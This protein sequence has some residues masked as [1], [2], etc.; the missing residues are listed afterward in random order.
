MTPDVSILIVNYNVKDYLLQCLRSI[1]A[2]SPGVSYEVVVVDN[3]SVDQSISELKP[4]FPTVNWIQLEENVGF[5]RGNNRGLEE[6]RGRYV[7]FLN[8]DTIIA[9]DTLETMVRFMD[10]H[11]DVGMAGC[12]V[13]NPD[14]T[15]QLACRRG[16]PTPWASFCKLSG[17]QSLF[18]KSKLFARYN[19]TYLPIDA[20]YEVDVLIGAFM[21]APTSL[22]KE[23]G[24]FDPDFFMYGEDV[25]LCYRVKKAGKKVMYTHQ[26]S[27]IHFKGESTRRS[28]INEVKVFYDAMEIFARKH[29]SRS[30]L[31]L[32]MMKAG[33]VGRA[34]VERVL[35]HAGSI[36]MI[37]A[38]ILSILIALLCAT[39]VRF[40][41]P[42]GFPPYAYPLVLFVVP[43]VIVMSL[44]SVGEY[45]EYRPTIRRSIVG[46]LVGFFF[47]SALTYFFKDFAF[48]RGVVLMTIG[49]SAV[50]MSITRGLA[51]AYRGLR[52]R[53][54]SRNII[55]VGRTSQAESII[56]SLRQAE[57]RKAHVLGVVSVDPYSDSTFAQAPIL[58]TMAVL[59]R[60]VRDVHADEVILA[61][62]SVSRAEAMTVMQRCAGTVS[63][64]HIA[65]EYSDIVTARIIN[66]V[67]G[68]EPTVALAPL[69]TFRNR[70]I[71]RLFDIV[72]SLVVLPFSVLR[73]SLGST[74]ARQAFTRWLSVLRGDSSVVGLYPDNKQRPWNK[75]GILSLVQLS[76]LAQ[77]DTHAI[78]Q[79]NDYY[80]DYFTIA[81]DVDILFKHLIGQQRGKYGS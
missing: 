76:D 9:Q 20:T 77:L 68:V 30:R 15:F 31:F 36:V 47:L 29:F 74:K 35:R 14:G 59:D 75:V 19:L 32:A 39:A 55:V 63:R 2:S 58:G 45:V 41:G 80:V 12:K 50:L 43:F 67:A 5:G 73:L 24:G 23:L 79:L 7:L 10:E 57:H 71:K 52:G 1:E 3:A 54:R 6:C 18:P 26:T 25:D 81:L 21:I 66:D 33:I 70:V 53:D 16:L 40:D 69:Q 46:L 64:F 38:D 48:S 22:M 8:P 44:I 17:L 49:F 34:M 27:I 28:S 13:L 78:E 72:C 62:A 60:I 65:T 11:A 51:S 56:R 4:D 61:D 42:F 37:A